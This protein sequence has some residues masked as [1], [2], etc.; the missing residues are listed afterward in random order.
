MPSLQKL[1][2]EESWAYQD[3]IQK[4]RELGRAEG[5]L[6]GAAEGRHAQLLEM[7]TDKFG[8]ADDA[9]IARLMSITDVNELRRLGQR[10][11]TVATWADLFAAD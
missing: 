5:R 3:T 4:G 7:G 6:V 11:L 1:I 2:E 9:T 10:L 8:P